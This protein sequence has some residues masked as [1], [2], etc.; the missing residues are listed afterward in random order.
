MKCY[1][2]PF[3]HTLNLR[4]KQKHLTLDQDVFN[5]SLKLVQYS[6]KLD[7]GHNSFLTIFF[8]EF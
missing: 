1:R 2:Y 8:K 5:Q 4:A 3:I 6:L 7:E